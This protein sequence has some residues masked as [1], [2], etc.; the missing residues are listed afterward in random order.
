MNKIIVKDLLDDNEIL[1]WLQELYEELEQV[2]FRTNSHRAKTAGIGY[3]TSSGLTLK[4][5]GQELCEGFIDIVSPRSAELID[6]IGSKLKI[7]YSTCQVN[8]NYITKPHYDSKNAGI[9]YL[10]SFG[11][12]EDGE[13]IIENR[14]FDTF[15]KLV[16]FEGSELFHWNVPHKGTKYSIIYHI[17]HI[18][19]NWM[20][21]NNLM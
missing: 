1:L 5:I 18:V 19:E 6:L 8:K 16:V 17:N 7:V 13:L 4:F 11:N 3:T 10:I 14:K 20:I 15:C 2:K 9:Q 21:K 12:Y